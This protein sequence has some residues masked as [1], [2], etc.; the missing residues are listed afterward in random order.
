MTTGLKGTPFH[1]ATARRCVS[2]SWY[3]WGGYAVPDVYTDPRAELAAIRTNVSMNEMSPI[4]KMEIAG[5]DAARFV[6][7]LIPRDVTRMK[8]GY[9][10]YAPW[11]T[12]A[13]LVIADGI[14]F[15]FA[16]NRFILSGDKSTETFKAQAGGYDVRISDVTDDYGI[17]ALQGPGSRAVLERATGEPWGELEFCRTR[18]TTIASAEVNVARQGFTGELGYELWVERAAGEAVW[19]AVAEA[20]AAFSIVP[21]GEYAIDVARIEAG[22]ILVSAEYTGASAAAEGKSADVAAVVG[23]FVTPYELNLG[24]CVNL[25]KPADFV[26]K[27]ALQRES[28]AG[29]KR[30]V[31]GLEFDFDAI[32]S[33]HAKAGRLID[34]APRVRWSRS[35]IL[36][37]GATVG[38]ATSLAWSPTLGRMIGFARVPTA[39]ARPGQTLTVAWSDY[40]G[41]FLGTVTGRIC[42]TPFVSTISRAA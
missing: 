41:D 18:T 23:D 8:V 40:Y 14:I 16:E 30:L 29:P 9:A 13:G 20:G 36:L 32:V 27:A 34:I 1:A 35:P 28:V 5:P 6:D 25:K 39:L 24:H 15:R 19:E 3:G 12:E 7:R 37:D 42:P 38:V 21:A 17:L 26:G 31:V 10:W 22:L 4:P 33:L 11:C 2:T